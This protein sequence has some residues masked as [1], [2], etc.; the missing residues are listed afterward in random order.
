MRRK[1]CLLMALPSLLP[2]IGMAQSDDAIRLR[3]EIEPSAALAKLPGKRPVYGW[4]EHIEGSV[5]EKLS[6]RGQAQLR[7]AGTSL[8]AAQIDYQHQNEELFARGQVRLAKSG[9]ISARSRTEA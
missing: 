6:L 2:F 9:T 3:I 8:S 4:A 1:L 7:Q 5:E